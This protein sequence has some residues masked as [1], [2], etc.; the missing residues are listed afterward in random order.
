MHLTDLS[1][2][3]FRSYREAVVRLEPGVSTFLGANG[4]GKTNLVEAVAYL[5]TLS[6]H[7]VAS[8]AALVRQGA[9]RSVVRAK[10]VRG[11][12]ALLIDLEIVP[13]KANRVRL[14]RAP[15]KRASDLLG[16]VKVVRFVPEDLSLVKGGPDERRRFLDE[17]LV[18]FTPGVAGVLADYERVVKQRSA[19]LKSAAKLTGRSREAALGSL[20]VWDD[21]AAELGGRITAARLGLVERLRGTVPPAYGAVA[22]ADGAVTRLTYQAR[23]ELPAGQAAGDA[24]AASGGSGLAA[25]ITAVLKAAMTSGRSQEIER[26]LT[27]WG[28]HRDDLALELNGLPARGYAS[29]GESWSLAL[30]LRLGSYELLRRDLEGDPILILDDVFAE[31][32]TKRRSALA[33]LTAGAEQVLVTAAV[34]QDVPAELVGAVYRV[35]GGEVTRG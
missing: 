21:K 11:D 15:V 17:L 30:A 8:D 1:L 4:Q 35:A 22:A 28:P 34:A 5:A 16:L 6:S 9:D 19:L 29:H 7:R 20:E 26:G 13:G 23:V 33:Q 27:L 12:R 31:L 32:D 14:G 3:D 10:V 25:Q 24:A 2:T 18:Q